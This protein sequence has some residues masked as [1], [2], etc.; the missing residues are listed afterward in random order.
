MDTELD[1]IAVYSQTTSTSAWEIKHNLKTKD[2]TV[3]VY[4]AD[5]EQ[6]SP[7]NITVD[8]FFTVTITFDE[9]TLQAG[10]AV[11]VVAEQTE[12]ISAVSS[13]IVHT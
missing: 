4:D 5:Y 11:L 6:I 3:F 2:L 10:H 8:D 1:D 12:D 13:N 9:D 7:F